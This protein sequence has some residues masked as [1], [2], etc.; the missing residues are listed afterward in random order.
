MGG[1]R[2]P[3][4]DLEQEEGLE[5]TLVSDELEVEG[6]G[7]GDQEESKIRAAVAVE[8]QILQAM[9]D[10]LVVPFPTPPSSQPSLTPSNHLPL[11]TSTSNSNGPI[12]RPVAA[13]FSSIEVG[14]GDYASRQQE[15]S[16]M[17]QQHHVVVAQAVKTSDSHPIK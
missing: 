11:A 13:V 6:G 16:G 10:Q 3:P 14:R 5:G 12:A 8:D 7:G 2:T 17:E 15:N 9:Q 4:R 1:R